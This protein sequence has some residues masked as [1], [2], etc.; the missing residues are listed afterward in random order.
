MNNM[1]IEKAAELCGGSICGRY[2]PQT[3]LGRIVIDSR[4]IQKNDIFAA[5]RGE[6]TDGHLYINKA[7]ELGAGCCLA[8]YVP[9]G[10]EGCVIVVN[11]VQGAVE[12]IAEGYREMLNIPIIGVTGSVGKTSAKEMIS[13]VLGA[14]FKVRKTE[15][16]LNNQ[17]GVPMTISSIMEDD[18]IAVIEMGI[19]GFGEMRGLSKIA[20]PNFAVYT[21]I[22]HAHLE[23][24]GDLDGVLRAKG[25]MTENMSPDAVV[26]VNGDDV[27]LSAWNCPCR[28][29]TFGLS[30]S[31]D[32]YAENVVYVN[33]TL[34]ECDVC[35]G[36]RKL[37][38]AI[39][40][41]GRHM[42]YA[43]LEGIGTGMLFGLTD[44]EIISGVSRFKTVGRR[45]AV[46]TTDSL[47]VIDDCYNANPDSVKCGIDSLAELASRKVCILGD[48]LELGEGSADMHYDVGRYAAEK[49]I[50]L[51]LCCG[52]LARHM[53]LGAGN[54]AIYYP[55]TEEL[56]KDLPFRLKKGD[57]VLV[58]ASRA[59]NF[60][61]VSEL[62]KA[63]EL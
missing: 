45:A 32:I 35:Y 51:V 28:K 13:A 58:K 26:L 34:T 48:M 47:T 33:E 46:F 22:G 59:M 44:E 8:E 10:V 56:K 29:M 9:D 19:S 5:Y 40:S 57:A 2:D 17:I 7:L 61:G 41:Y 42:V 27:K 6:K 39:P 49:G 4:K 60:D 63:V 14:K 18:E 30:S 53:A 50:D 55:N 25:E 62:L 54:G 20:K 23:F 12:A 37:H 38:V 21:L 11:D 15:G 16:N 24:L 36:E 3:E 31:A 43:A 52:E 1:T